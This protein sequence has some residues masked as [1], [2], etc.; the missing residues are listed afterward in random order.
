MSVIEKTRVNKH[1]KCDGVNCN[2]ELPFVV[3]SPEYAHIY[4]QQ[5]GWKADATGH[6]CPRCARPKTA[7]PGPAPL[8]TVKG[9]NAS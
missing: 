6:Y 4:A 7:R 5:A 9:K 1:I 3:T 8:G 2:A